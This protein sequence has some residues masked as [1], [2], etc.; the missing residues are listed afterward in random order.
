MK[1]FIGG[2]IA[3]AIV[4]GAFAIVAGPMSDRDR[5][6]MKRGAGRFLRSAGAALDAVRR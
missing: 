1:S 5:R 6:R 3:G 4:G 2:V